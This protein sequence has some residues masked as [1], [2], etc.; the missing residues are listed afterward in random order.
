[1]AADDQLIVLRIGP[2]VLGHARGPV[3]P[4]ER[5]ALQA[6]GRHGDH[7]GG[8]RRCWLS[9]TVTSTRWNSFSSL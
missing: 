1:M 8:Y 4:A 6:S 9:A 7:P 5:P 2:P 3:V